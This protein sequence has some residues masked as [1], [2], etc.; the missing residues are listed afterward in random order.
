MGQNTSPVRTAG[1]QIVF[2]ITSLLNDTASEMAYW[3]L[4]GLLLT[5]GA[6][7]AQLGM[8]EGVAEGVA[9]GL[10]L[11]SGGLTDRLTKRKPLVVA[12]YA[13]ANFAKPLLA[14]AGSWWHVFLIRFAD[15]AA[16]GIRSAPRDVMLA[17]SVAPQDLGSAFGLLQTMDTAGAILGPLIAMGLLLHWS[18]KTVLLAAAVP[19]ILCVAIVSLFTRETRRSVSGGYAPDADPHHDVSPKADLSKIQPIAEADSS[20]AGAAPAN[21]DG[22]SQRFYYLIFINTLF[23][24]AGS[25]DMFLVLRA[26]ENGMTLAQAPLFGLVFNITFTLFSWPAGKLSDKMPRRFL[27]AAGFLVYAIVYTIFAKAPSLFSLW[28]A[29]AFYGLFYALT[30]PVLKAMV[31]DAVTPQTR[32]RAIGIYSFANSVTVLLASVLTGWLWKI[33]GGMLPLALAAGLAFV[34]TGLMIFYREPSRANVATR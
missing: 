18:L 8:I 24:L 25:S 3:V 30:A 22:F 19:G 31:V 15:R 13:I 26:Q 17:E 16:K 29:M 14:F 21:T 12:G 2:G 27:A 1:N 7:P 28:S 20:A 23:S 10:K 4:P 5:L 9:S 6:G 11:W 34:S 32:G 33:Y